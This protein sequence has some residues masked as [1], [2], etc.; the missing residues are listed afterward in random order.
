MVC[1]GKQLF[2]LLS[3]LLKMKLLLD[4]RALGCSVSAAVNIYAGNRDQKKKKNSQEWLVL[5]PIKKK[6]PKEEKNKNKKTI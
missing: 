4:D 2:Q 3:W 1:S 6:L 5:L